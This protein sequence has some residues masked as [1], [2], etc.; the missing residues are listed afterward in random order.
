MI[1]TLRGVADC[2]TF[3]HIENILQLKTLLLSQLTP[4]DD[5]LFMYLLIIMGGWYSNSTTR[6]SY[7]YPNVYGF[8]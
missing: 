6:L 7:L 1:Y 4:D 3:L 5:L 2:K 8:M